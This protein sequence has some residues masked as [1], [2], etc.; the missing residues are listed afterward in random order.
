MAIIG[1]DQSFRELRLPLSTE[2]T[3]NPANC[4]T[5]QLGRG[6]NTSKVN[7]AKHNF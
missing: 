4:G 2:L 6:R 7:D 3:Y 1:M 5:S